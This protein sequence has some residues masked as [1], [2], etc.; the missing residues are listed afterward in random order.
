MEKKMSTLVRE[1]FVRE[2]IQSRVEEAAQERRIR[3]LLLAKRLARKAE[4]S[5]ARARLAL[6]RAI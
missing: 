2:I 5:A 3:Q 4:L 6:A 1:E